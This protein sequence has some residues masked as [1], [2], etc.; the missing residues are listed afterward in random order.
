MPPVDGGHDQAMPALRRCPVVFLQQ[1][2]LTAEVFHCG[3]MQPEF[4]IKPTD[5]PAKGE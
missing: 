2:Q 4:V 5:N 1:M 3:R